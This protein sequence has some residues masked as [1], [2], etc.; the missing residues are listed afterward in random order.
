MKFI[1]DV[2]LSAVVLLFTAALAPSV[3]D[4]EAQGRR[5]ECLLFIDGRDVI[6]GTCMF[7]PIGRDG[8]FQIMSLNGS[9]FAQVQVERPGVAQGYWNG[10]AYQGHAHDNLGTLTRKEACWSNDSASV[11]AW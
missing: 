9:S 3:P 11:C 10:G 2:W 7:S 8:S 4:A 1:F 6:R 5:A